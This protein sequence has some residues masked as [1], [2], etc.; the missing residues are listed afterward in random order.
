[1][2]EQEFFDVVDIEAMS[3]DMLDDIVGGSGLIAPSACA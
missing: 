3:D 1:M 2:E